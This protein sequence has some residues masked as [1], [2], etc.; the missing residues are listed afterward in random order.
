MPCS[1]AYLWKHYEMQSQIDN[2][3]FGDFATFV[4]VGEII[5]DQ[6]QV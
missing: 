2:L 3:D 4:D 6:I 1:L 5:T